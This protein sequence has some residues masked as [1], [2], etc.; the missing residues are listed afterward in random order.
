MN[1][2]GHTIER[3]SR[4]DGIKALGCIVPCSGNMDNEI[5]ARISCAWGAFYA[6]KNH[7]VLFRGAPPKAL[8]ITSDGT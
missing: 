7:S 3:R 5:D 4:D 8:S 1:V 6:K 2:E